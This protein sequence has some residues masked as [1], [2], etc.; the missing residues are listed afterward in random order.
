MPQH[1]NQKEKK[2]EANNRVQT[3]NQPRSKNKQPV[4]IAQKSSIA[5][6]AEV[7]EDRAEVVEVGE[8][9]GSRRRGADVDGLRRGW[10]A[11]VLV[12]VVDGLRR[13][14][15][16]GEGLSWRGGGLRRGGGEVEG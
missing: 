4:E 7:A 3:K 16:G 15:R 1:Q 10:I 12:A 2:K 14:G 5:E 9:A 6:V 8:A 13:A 11:E